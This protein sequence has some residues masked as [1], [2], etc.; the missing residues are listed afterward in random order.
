MTNAKHR[1]LE[2]YADPLPNVDL[3]ELQG[4]L[5][6]IE[7][8]DSVGRSTQVELLRNWLEA[9]GYA[10]VDTGMM[11]STLTKDGLEAAKS[12]HTLGPL[13]MGLFYMTDFADRLERVMVPALRAGFVV[14]TDRYFYSIV[15]RAAA[16]RQDS[17][18]L[19][20]VAGCA[21]VPHATF[22]LRARVSEVV[23]RTARGRKYF[24]YWESGMDVPYGPNRYQSFLLYQ[25]RLIEILDSLAERYGFTV[26]D[27]NR[28]P[29]QIFADLR[30]RIG[31]LLEIDPL[32][33]S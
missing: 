29:D 12:G 19:E 4:K 6:V 30:E 26:I 15:A 3:T 1:P 25:S 2:F 27:A 31:R 20:R 13:T 28:P 8:P 16:R 22:Y 7:G 21:L 11:R 24:E 9:N 33:S 32:E 10:V 14:L 18:W 17:E 5:L 23:A